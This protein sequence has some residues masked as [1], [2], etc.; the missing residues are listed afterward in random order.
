M[1]QVKAHI[2]V[3]LDGHT[4]TLD[5]ELDWLPGE[6][7]AIVGKHCLEADCLLMGANTYTISLSIGAGGRTKNSGLLSCRT[8]IP[9]LRRTAAWSS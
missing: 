8:T 9:T 1:K 5:N 4:A 3:S 6:V 7:K 2:A